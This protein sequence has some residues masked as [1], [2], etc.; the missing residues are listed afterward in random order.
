[1]L[2]KHTINITNQD[3]RGWFVNQYIMN[4]VE[5]FEPE[6]LDEANDKFNT[7][8]QEHEAEIQTEHPVQ[9]KINT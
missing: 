1:M 9:E 2:N 4:W 5:K 3:L 7:L 8:I 6:V